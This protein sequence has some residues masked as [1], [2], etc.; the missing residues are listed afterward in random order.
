M[1]KYNEFYY[2]PVKILNCLMDDD[3][4]GPEMDETQLA[5]LCGLIREHR[6]QKIV[7]VGVAAGG[8]TS[9]ILNCISMLKLDPQ[10]F[11]ID[12]SMN[13]YRDQEKKTGYLIDKCKKILDTE[14]DHALYTGEYAVNHLERIGGNID[15]LILDTVHSLPGELLDYL[16]FY[17]FLKEGAV[18]VLH[19]IALNHFHNQPAQ[20]AAKVLFDSVTADKLYG[21]TDNGTLLNIGAFAITGDT[22]RYID[23]IFSALTLTWGYEVQKEELDLYRNF[24]SKYYSE[25]DLELFDMAVRM[26]QQTMEETG[27][28]KKR[29]KQLRQDEFA[30]MYKWI[31]TLK[32][33]KRVY[34]YGCGYWGQRLYQLLNNCGIEIEGYTI[35]DREQKRNEI[36]N[37]FYLSEIDLDKE[38]V[39]VIGVNPSLQAEIC[40]E[41]SKH[42]IQEYIIPE[43]YVYS[44]LA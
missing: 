35:S 42:G 20:I 22:G 36:K 11:S 39:I 17:P 19:D 10:M 32:S 25:D 26:N 28:D 21:I 43:K 23:S 44:Y 16:A 3:G 9:V 34:I 8:T 5:F 31:E 37:I 27:K 7:E 30:E 4:Y 40:T 38:D 15:F 29:I 24:Y 13:F 12:L 1:A 41:L 14:V 18:V 2:E 33:K 6:P